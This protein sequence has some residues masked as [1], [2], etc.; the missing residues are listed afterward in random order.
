MPDN[1][2]DKRL[3]R[4]AQKLL[5]SASSACIAE[6]A[7]YPLDVIKT[8]LQVSSGAA[9]VAKPNFTSLYAGLTPALL[10]HIPYTSVRIFTFEKL[11]QQ[12]T[13]DSIASRCPLCFNLAAGMLA[14]G[15]GQLIATPADLVK[16]RMQADGKI[17]DPA[18]RRY[19][20][21][22]PRAFKTILAQ[23][24]GIRG[25]WRGGLPAVQRAALVNLG[26][27]T[28][29]DTAKRAVLQSGITGY[30]DNVYTHFLSSVCSGFVASVVSTPADVIKSRLMNQDQAQNNPTNYKGVLDCALLTWRA[31]G[32]RGLYRGF[33]PTWLRLGPWQLTFWMSYE[34][35]RKISGIE[36][37]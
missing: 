1:S 20:N 29:Y 31:E 21:G 23:E 12:S 33:I 26:E 15:L 2:S 25:L 8:R 27:L 6:T 13:T 4:Q 36:P 11:R 16:V 28:T 30:N 9:A 7:T 3:Y 32:F 14:G 37:F 35:L 18:L 5:L 22:V 19:T 34:Q 17:L 10:R 24:G